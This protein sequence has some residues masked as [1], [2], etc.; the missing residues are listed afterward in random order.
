MEIFRLKCKELVKELANVIYWLE[1]D[2][3]PVK[4]YTFLMR[5]VFD[6]TI[7]KAQDQTLDE[8]G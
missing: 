6:M 5:T 3:E 1:I 2:F 8:V 7:N 4:F